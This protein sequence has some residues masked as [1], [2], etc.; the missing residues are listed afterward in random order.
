[1]P[2]QLPAGLMD[3][4]VEFFVAEDIQL[5]FALKDGHRMPFKEFESE[6]SN[7]VLA[8]LSINSIKTM[9]Y[10]AMGNDTDQKMVVQFLF[11]NYGGF[12][13]SPDMINGELQEPEY[14]ACPNRATCKYNGK[15]CDPL[16]TP[17]GQK[18]SKREIEILALGANGLT[19]Q[20]IAD[21]LF[22]AKS[23]V[24]KHCKNISKKMGMAR[25]ADLT[26]FAIKMNLI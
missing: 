18:L 4:N 6:V 22:L 10:R 17:I 9:A 13:N 7:K 26:R 1:M 12:D 16:T 19:H 23:T 5:P 15:G 21:K 14:W 8:K 11:C 24:A 20:A 2:H 25:Q 3:N